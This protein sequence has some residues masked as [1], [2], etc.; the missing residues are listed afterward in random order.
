[1]TDIARC[2][3][4]PR[5]HRPWARTEA[6][7]AGTGRSRVRPGQQLPRDASGSLRTYA[8]DERTW[9]VGQTYCTGEVPEQHRATSSGGDG[10]K[11]FG[12]REPA[13]Q[14]ASRTPSR[15]DALSALERVRQAAAKDKK[16][17]FTALL[18][19]IYNRNTLR[20]AYF[21]LKKEA[22]PGVDG[23]TWRHYGEELE[24][25]L[26]DLSAKLKHGAYRAKPVRR[27]FIPKADGRQR[28]LGVPALEDKIVQRAAV[29]VLNAIYET[30]FL[31]FSYGFRPG[32][33][34]HQALDA[35]YT[36]LLTRKVNWVLDLD[37]QGFFDGL[38]HEWLVKFIEHRVADR[39]VVRLIQKWLN[40]GVL[41]DGK[42]IRTEEGTPQGG[43]VSP[44]LANV[45]LHYV[46]DLWVQAWRQKRAHG[47]VI[48]VRF[49]DDIVVGFNSKADADQFRAELTERMRKFHLELHPEKT[50]LLEFGPHAIDQRQW[51]GEGKPETFNFLG[52]THICVKKKSNGRYTVLRQTI[53]KRLQSKLNEVKAELQRRMHDPIPEVGKWLQ[54][55]VRGHIR[56]YGVPMNQPALA[57]FRFQAGRLWHRAL[58]RRSQNG[59]VLWD[60]MRRL[61]TRWLPL[62]TV[63]HPYPLRRLGVVT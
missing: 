42:R 17:R 10:G 39:R 7:R 56:Y 48:V 45:Y 62:P 5:G 44:L 11:R 29:E 23:E 52:F 27:V 22:A 53:R 36:G 43:S 19:H 34:Q 38:S 47:N 20:M 50:R 32:R 15:E 55:V 26:Q 60:R 28:P 21:R 9:E 2:N 30:D 54:A 3:G 4:V 16:L 57:I 6:P 49:A 61:I 18:H 41:E 12:Q 8:D 58:S 24:G 35:L 14:N 51:R 1:C 59:R 40:A 31:G 13:Q 25:N 37:I 63:C 33:S 46:F